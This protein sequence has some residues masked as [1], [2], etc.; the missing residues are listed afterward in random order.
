MRDYQTLFI[1]DKYS[2]RLKQD[3]VKRELSDA[4]QKAVEEV[5]QHEQASRGGA[6]FNGQALSLATFDRNGLEAEFVEYKLYLAYLKSPELR[7][8]LGL[9]PL[10]ISCLT[11]SSDSILVGRR[12]KGMAQYP[13]WYELAPSG[14]IDPQSVK[15]EK[16]DIAGQ[17]LSELKEETG[18]D[19][20][21]VVAIRPFSLIFDPQTG[22]YE[23]AVEIELTS[24]MASEPL[25]PTQEYRSLNWLPPSQVADF[26]ATNKKRIV[27]LSVYLLELHNLY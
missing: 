6:L 14:G 11:K 10:S 17:A 8:E 13:L 5:W 2:F 12:E 24:H 21:D 19:K 25:K 16:L 27:P 4:T 22:V 3:A 15:K 20:K 1:S 18:I 7:D 23:I 9:R 26:V